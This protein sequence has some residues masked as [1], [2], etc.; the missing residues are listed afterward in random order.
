MRKGVYTGTARDL[1]ASDIR[2][3]RQHTG[4]S[5]E[6]LKRLIALNKGMYPQASCGRQVMEI[7]LLQRMCTFR[8]ILGIRGV[9]DAGGVARIWWNLIHLRF[10]RR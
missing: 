4:A 8:L 10:E 9:N 3:L 5:N 1:L 7:M 6:W 2:N